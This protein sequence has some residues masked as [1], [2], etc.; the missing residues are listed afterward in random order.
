MIVP[1]RMVDAKPKIAVPSVG[2]VPKLL[3]INP[4]P[5]PRAMIE[6]R[7]SIRLKS[8]IGILLGIKKLSNQYI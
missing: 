6:T 2:I 1:A 8:A 7:D 4:K 3:P 5:I